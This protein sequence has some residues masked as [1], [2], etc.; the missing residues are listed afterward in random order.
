MV[1]RRVAMVA[2]S[3]NDV[4]HMTTKMDQIYTS[5]NSQFVILL[6][7]ESQNGKL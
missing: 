1:K 4:P 5:P 6:I 2:K 3:R 7:M